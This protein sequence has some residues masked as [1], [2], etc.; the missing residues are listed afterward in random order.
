MTFFCTHRSVSF[1]SLVVS[2]TRKTSLSSN[3]KQIPMTTARYSSQRL[4]TLRPKLGFFIKFLFSEVKRH[5]KRC[6]RKGVRTKREGRHCE[7][8][9]S[10]SIEQIK[11]ELI[12]AEA[13]WTEPPSVYTRW[14]LGPKEV[15]PCSQPYSRNYLLLTINP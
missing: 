1:S 12:E 5:R 6:G 4:V 9:T 8:K 11:Y 3:Q 7:N 2:T 13:A 15:G 10:N 14:D